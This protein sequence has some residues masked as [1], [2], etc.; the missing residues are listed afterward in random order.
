MINLWC[1]WKKNKNSQ[2]LSQV[3]LYYYL[4]GILEGHFYIAAFS[5]K[6]KHIIC[7]S[8]QDCQIAKKMNLRIPQSFYQPLK[9]PNKKLC[10]NPILLTY[11]LYAIGI[12]FFYQSI[13]A[14]HLNRIWYHLKQLVCVFLFGNFLL[15]LHCMGRNQNKTTFCVYSFYPIRLIICSFTNFSLAEYILCVQFLS[16]EEDS[17]FP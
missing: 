3:L 11:Q 12:V 6:V 16:N 10:K 15:S 7:F 13:S 1:R 9:S 5:I 4:P 14:Y 2:H 8:I 17:L